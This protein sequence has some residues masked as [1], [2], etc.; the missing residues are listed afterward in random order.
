MV[1]LNEIL[2]GRV[3]YLIQFFFFQFF[4]EILKTYASSKALH[5]Q[6]MLQ[7]FQY[8]DCDV[9]A[10]SGKFHPE[11]G[12]QPGNHVHPVVAALFL[13]KIKKLDD[14]FLLSNMAGL[15]T[16]RYNRQKLSVYHDYEL[17]FNLIKLNYF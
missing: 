3:L 17:L 1:L 8:Q 6:V 15:V 4:Q 2:D 7:S 16:S 13:P 14:H 12:H 10:L 11:H 5:A 9:Q